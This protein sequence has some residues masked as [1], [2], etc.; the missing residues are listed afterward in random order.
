MSIQESSRKKLIRRLIKILHIA[1]VILFPSL[2]LEK[3]HRAINHDS[4]MV[5]FRYKHLSL[6]IHPWF[7]RYY[8]TSPVNYCNFKQARCYHWISSPD[9]L[10]KKPFVIEPN[11]HPLSIVGALSPVPIEPIDV[12]KNKRKAIELVYLNPQCK[13]ILI[14]SSG[15]LELFE[16]YCPEVLNKC[17]IVR[18]GTIPQKENLSNAESK[19]AIGRINFLCLASDFTKKGVDLLLDAWFEFPERKRHQLIVACS[20]VPKKYKSRVRGENVTFIL[21]SPL[22]S[23]EKE[24]LYRKAHVVIGPLHIDGGA[25]IMEAMEYGLPII[26]MRS[27]R[28]NDQVMNNNGIVVDVPFYFYDE[29]YGIEWRT[30]NDFFRL[31]EIAK[32]KGGFNITKEG[33]V[34]AL[35]FFSKNPDRISE[36]GKQSYELAS[37]EYSLIKRNQQLLRIYKNILFDKECVA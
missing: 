4:L 14:E 36:M 8:R 15:Q 11:D 13:K 29:G 10:N 25:N 6:D 28:S 2:V 18:P 34:K 32:S 24:M 23:K 16:R 33:F 20:F 21:K 30:W 12:L 9:C 7:D 27:Q 35:N 5:Y 17:E 26:T 22:S 37:N 31:L 3:I 1:R 19:H